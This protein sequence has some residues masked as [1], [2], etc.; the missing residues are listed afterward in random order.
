MN[1]ANAVYQDT[2]ATSRP[3][4][5]AY[6]STIS[7]GSGCPA[8]AAVVETGESGVASGTL[9]IT[10]RPR[11]VSGSPSVDISQSRIALI[12]SSSPSRTLSSR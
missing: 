6:R 12:R 8:A 5:A 1:Q 2:E 4:R 7:A 10:S 9:Y 3:E 11:S